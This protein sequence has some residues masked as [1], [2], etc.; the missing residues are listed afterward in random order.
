MKMIALSFLLVAGLM[1]CGN[2]KEPEFRSVGHFKVKTLGLQQTT[3][4]FNVTY[5]NPNNFGVTVK[6]TEA[7]VYMDS[8][9]LGKFIQDSNV[10]VQKNAEFTI[11][12]SGNISL[13]T[14]LQMNLQD[15]GTREI[16]VRADGSTKVGKA[17]IYLNK[18][19]H[20]QGKHRLEDIQF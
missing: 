4:G 8:V 11:P 18:P 20:Y 12:L 3:I 9:F 16:M 2:V 17:G 14:A 1:G 15:L 5:F 6:E 19:I 10:L 7:D 13:Q